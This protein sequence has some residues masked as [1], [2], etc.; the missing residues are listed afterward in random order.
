M[1]SKT[2]K[3]L[4]PFVGMFLIYKGIDH[5]LAYSFSW[6]KGILILLV[7]PIDTAYSYLF[8]G[9]LALEN[10][11]RIWT[12]KK[13]LDN[14]IIHT[15]WV[16][17]VIH[18]FTGFSYLA[19]W[20]PDALF[21]FNVLLIFLIVAERMQGISFSSFVKALKSIISVVGNVRV[22]YLL[23][24]IFFSLIIV[25]AANYTSYDDYWWLHN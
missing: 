11:R 18:H 1:T 25:L 6:Q 16:W 4:W 9:L 8:F 5:I 10:T 3:F 13:R 23:L 15:F 2:F 14:L 24:A 20:I 12:K 21:S 22:E 7:T 17:V 19:N